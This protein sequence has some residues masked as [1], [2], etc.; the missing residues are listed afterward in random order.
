VPSY[1]LENPQT[2]RVHIQKKCRIAAERDPAKRDEFL[3]QI[4]AIDPDELVFLD[5]MGVSLR[6]SLLYGWG[7]KG[8]DLIEKVSAKRGKNL[9]VI[10]AFDSLGMICTS[11][12]LGAMKR[13]DFERFLCL[14][15]LPCLTPG[16]VLVLDNATIH[17]G[18]KIATLVKKAGC[19]LLYLPP[20]SP[21]F[22]PIE[23]AWAFLKKIIRRLA[24]RDDDSRET[25]LASALASI[26][27]SLPSACFRH[28]GY[29]QSI[30][31]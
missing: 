23:L 12:Q 1:C 4:E 27:D 28:C 11:H 5:E 2:N 3:K 17:Q 10:G 20:Y 16:S 18:G 19:R 8:K 9:S 21:D 29:H 14:K 25:A 31:K 26:P 15:L 30:C 24:P 6:L 22:N 7:K 13:V